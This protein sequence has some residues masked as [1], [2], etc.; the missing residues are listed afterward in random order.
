MEVGYSTISC[1][2]PTVQGVAVLQINWLY[3]TFLAVQTHD[4]PHHKTYQPTSR[5]RNSWRIRLGRLLPLT[6]D[7]VPRGRLAGT[8]FAS[9]RHLCNHHRPTCIRKRCMPCRR[10]RPISTTLDNLPD[11]QELAMRGRSLYS[12]RY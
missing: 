7:Q 2:K 3:H 1:I 8:P 4:A 12:G 5:Q 11:I 9:Q 10:I 6:S